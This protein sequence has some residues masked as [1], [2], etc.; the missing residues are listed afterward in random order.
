MGMLAAPSTIIIIMEDIHLE[1]F[2]HIQGIT[3]FQETEMS[4]TGYGQLRASLSS[5]HHVRTV[6]Y[7]WY[8]QA[9]SNSLIHLNI[10]DL[11]IG[12]WTALEILDGI[13]SV[14]DPLAVLNGYVNLGESRSITSTQNFLYVRW[15][16]S[17][18]GSSRLHAVFTEATLPGKG[19]LQY[20]LYFIHGKEDMLERKFI[21]SSSSLP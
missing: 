12:N 5:F 2:Q 20:L 13:S 14:A 6:D 4:R 3:E 17:V 1:Q 18:E 10:L 11:Q 7:L 21:L 19:H 8:I 9:P 15:T 16:G